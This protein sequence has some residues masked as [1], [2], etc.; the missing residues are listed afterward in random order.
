MASSSAFRP[1]WTKP[2]YPCCERCAIYLPEAVEGS[3]VFILPY[4]TSFGNL[5]DAFFPA[6]PCDVKQE[7]IG[8]SKCFRC[9]KAAHPCIPFSHPEVVT[10]LNTVME[11]GDRY[12][13]SQKSN[14]KRLSL[15]T[16]REFSVLNEDWKKYLKK[17]QANR[18]NVVGDT[19]LPRKRKAGSGTEY[20]GLGDM[21]AVE[22]QRIRTALEGIQETLSNL[23]SVMLPYFRTNAPVDPSLPGLDSQ[24]NDEETA[25]GSSADSEYT[26]FDG[27]DDGSF[28]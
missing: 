7:L 1:G 9:A 15:D 13:D 21:N 24:M 10:K 11:A 17:Y 12:L 26:M 8:T 5:A 18:K 6:P 2:N 14:D 28:E 25:S 20:G 22:M 16:W 23:S 4:T 3:S 19:A 27:F